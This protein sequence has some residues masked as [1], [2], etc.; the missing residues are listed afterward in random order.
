MF[1][2]IHFP[3]YAQIRDFARNIYGRWQL[4]LVLFQWDAAYRREVIVSIL[5]LTLVNYS[6]F[7]LDSPYDYIALLIEFAIIWF[8]LGNDYSILPR[9][10]RPSQN[11]A[12]FTVKTARNITYN[13][14]THPFRKI[15]PPKSEEKL[16]MYNPFLSRSVS[17]ETALC[18][19][20]VNDHLMTVKHMPYQIAKASKDYISSVHQIRYLAIR[21]ANKK[22]H[23][24]N[25]EKLALNASASALV[26]RSPIA[27]CKTNYFQAL[28]TAEAFRSRIYRQNLRGVDEINTDMTQYYPVENIEFEGKKRLRI[29]DDYY[30]CVAGHIGATSLFFTE[31]RRILMMFQGTGKVI[32]ANK[33]QL[34]GSGS[35]DFAD[36]EGKPDEDLRDAIRKCMARET[37]EETG[38]PQHYD[39][40]YENTLITGFF[41]WVD[42]A[43]KPEFS[44]I[45]K[46]GSLNV[47]QECQTDGDEI[48]K[49]EE[50]PVT[51]H[52][53]ADFKKVLAYVTKHKLPISLSAL[54]ALHRMTVIAGYGDP[55]A[56][57]KQKSIYKRVEEFLFSV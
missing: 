3:S 33:V 26:G 40:M 9:E 51:I 2:K 29:L 48:T 10:Y 13:S 55:G 52:K 25:G 7:D 24:T 45:T 22:Q 20:R 46:A 42:R 31:N 32:D 34:G 23:T 41:H 50:I 1:Q 57:R 16:D 53:I 35:M 28:L 21:V 43:Y 30:E 18:S 4:F 19:D 38:L 12:K 14:R 17:Q 15:L 44:G 36:I 39:H 5:A 11:G 56:S 49:V 47:M 37:A 6:I 27:V 54:M 8:Q